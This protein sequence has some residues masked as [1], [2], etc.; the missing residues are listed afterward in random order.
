MINQSFRGSLDWFSD[1]LLVALSDFQSHNSKDHTKDC[2]DP[3]PGYYLTLMISE[4]LVMMMQGAHQKDP[5]ALSMLSSRIFEITY[6][7]DHADVF[8][9]ENT[10]EYRDQQFLA[11]DHRQR[12]DDSPQRQATRIAHKY[13]CG[14]SIVP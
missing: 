7:Q 10:A 2:H 13:R 6:L 11:N 4:L 1:N 12:G 14:I 3:K 9:Q 8:H 5:P